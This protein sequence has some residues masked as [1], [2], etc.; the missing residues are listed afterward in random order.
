MAP[1]RSHST[2]RPTSAPSLSPSQRLRHSV[3]ITMSLVI[4]VASAMLATITMAVAADR[5]PRKTS[6]ASAGAP[7]SSGSVRMKAS[8]L[9]RDPRSLPAPASTIGTTHSVNTAR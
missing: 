9:C 8:G 5:P 2:R 7:F 6:T 1:R 3:G 4:M